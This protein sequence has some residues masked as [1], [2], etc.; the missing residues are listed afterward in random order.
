[1]QTREWLTREER[2][3]IPKRSRKNG[4]DKGEYFKRERKMLRDIHRDSKRK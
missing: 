2:G 4:K 1:M 3:Q